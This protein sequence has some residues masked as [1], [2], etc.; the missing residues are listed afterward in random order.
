MSNC[1]T[2]FEAQQWAFSFVKKHNCEPSGADLL[3]SGEMGFS[4]TEFL[5]HL[6]TEMPAENWEHFKQNVKL[7]CEGWPPQYLLGQ[8]YFYGLQLKVTLETLIPRPETEE[9]VDWA[10]SDN[11]HA[12]KNVA[13]IGTGT[14]AIGLALKNERPKWQM[15]LTD[16]S[17]GA[18]A[19]AQEN[20]ATLGLE[21]SLA[22]GDLLSALTAG[23]YDI[24]MCNPPYISTDE[25]T[26]MDKSV[27]EHEPQLALFASEQGLAIYRRLFEQI[28]DYLRIGSKL[29]LEIGYLQGPTIVA[30]AKQAFPQAEVTLK[31]DITAHDRMVRVVFK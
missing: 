25:K 26:V 29:Y 31:R 20:A 23:P 10:L 24:I 11:D 19:V 7:Y 3:L 8:A 15:T 22:Q 2:F 21:V 14:G 5:L 4:A 1:P 30:M 6:R 17:A 16:I 18:L 13:D 12:V 28:Q 9:L 27:L